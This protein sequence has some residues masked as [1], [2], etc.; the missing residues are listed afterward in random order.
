MVGTV[1][2]RLRAATAEAH[3]RLETRLGMVER[4]AAPGERRRLVESFH[5]C[6]E[7]KPAGR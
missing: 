3:E 4:A 5:A 1:L 6:E 2:A 7:P